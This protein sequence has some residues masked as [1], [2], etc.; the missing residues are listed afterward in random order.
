MKCK[1]EFL[2]FSLKCKVEFLNFSLKCKDA[3]ASLEPKIPKSRQEQAADAVNS[4]FKYKFI[5]FK[6]K[7]IKLSILVY[8]D[9]KILLEAFLDLID[10]LGFD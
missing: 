1:V 7:S 2:N 5:N 4:L 9:N 3:F 10:F 8:K 6:P